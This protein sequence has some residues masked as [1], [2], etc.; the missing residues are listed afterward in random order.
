MNHLRLVTEETNVV[1][2][3]DV[4]AKH[5]LEYEKRTVLN[6]EKWLSKITTFDHIW[7]EQEILS[8]RKHIGFCSDQNSVLKRELLYL[9]NEKS[10]NITEE[11]TNKGIQFLCNK[12]FKKDGSLRETKDFP[13]GSREIEV[14]R[15]FSHFKFVGV[16]YECGWD[17]SYQNTSPIYSV[18]SKSGQS[19]D[20][21]AGAFGSIEVVG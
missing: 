13:F 16:H 19:F 1:S 11:Q 14:L 5:E 18:V 12:A 4:I 3:N 21:I 8:F 15:D 6:Y 7:T 17:G 9:I 20:Y 10:F 2:L